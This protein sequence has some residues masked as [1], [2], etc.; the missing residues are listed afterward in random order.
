MRAAGYIRVSSESQVDGGSL[1]AQNHLVVNECKSRDWELV[2]VYRE[3]GRSAHSESINQRPVFK[4]LLEDARKKRFDI[5]VVHTLDRWSRNLRV[6]LESLKI[7]AENDIGLV[8][9]TENIDYTTAQGKLFTQMLG[10]FAEYFSESLSTHVKK[11]HSER[12]RSG[13]HLGGI[14]F[15]YLSCWSGKDGSRVLACVE[16]HSGGIHQISEEAEAISELFRRYAAGATST[17]DLAI[18]MNE[19]GFRTRN[20]KR[21][22][23]HDGNETSGPRFFTNSSIRGILHNR[24]YAGSVK[25]G[26]DY[27]Q[28]EHEPVISTELLESVRI[29][30]SKNSGRS[31]TIG[32]RRTRTYL[33]KGLARCADCGMNLWAQTYRN[34]NRYYREQRATRSHGECPAQGGSVPCEQVDDQIVKIFGSIKLPSDWEQRVVAKIQTKDEVARVIQERGR[35]NEKLRR[36]GLAFVDGLYETEYRRQK[37]SLLTR[38]ESLVIPEVDVAKEAGQL[39]CNLP[40]LWDHASLDERHRL[41]SSIVQAVRI[42]L[43]RAGI[44]KSIELKPP[45]TEIGEHMPLLA[46]A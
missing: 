30:L 32:R 4:Q 9:I 3:E 8:S 14:P 41:L 7:L 25:H 1:P 12:A 17:A 31:A 18:W 10:S 26:K 20:N 16:E 28:G 46:G 39:I 27:L 36:L 45:F 19:Q 35:V 44:I 22:P 40:A 21:L 24:F 34:G 29:M 13:R 37:Q 15:G 33:L 11:G 38:L 43:K 6:T 23:T 42:D 5:V 2:G